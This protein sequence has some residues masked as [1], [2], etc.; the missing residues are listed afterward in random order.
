[1]PFAV[2]ETLTYDVTYASMLTAGTAISR[3]ESRQA[4][5][6]RTSYQIVVEGR[7]IPVFQ[8]LYN[9][10]YRMETLLDTTTLLPHRVSMY[11]EEGT[12]KRTSTTRFDRGS[13]RAFFEVQT[14]TKAEATIDVP[15]QIQDGLSSLYVLRTM[16]INPGDA[17]SLPVLDEGSLYR[18]NA[19][20]GPPEQVAVPLGTLEAVKLNVSILDPENQPVAQNAAVWVTT[21]R[22]RLPI[23]M[24]ADLAVGS[25]VLLLRSATP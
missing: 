8:K 11:S 10:Y 4:T 23:K 15:E 22:Q 25:F 2:G 12:R 5:A 17:F 16:S 1:M 18:V 13:N 19:S 9:L 20:V 14:D 6:S 21:D 3:I 24:Q 7:P